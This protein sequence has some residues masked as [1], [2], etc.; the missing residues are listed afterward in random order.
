MVETFVADLSHLDD[1]QGLVAEFRD[2]LQRGRPYDPALRQNLQR[3]FAK[4][5]AE[6]LLAVDDTG[7]AVGYVQQRYRYSLWYGDMEATLEDLFVSAATRRQ[8]VATHLLRF[9]IERAKDR[10]CQTIKLDTN[11]SNHDAIRLYQRTGF[12]SGSTRF[13]NSRQLSFEKYLGLDS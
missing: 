6:F 8:G 4:G 7:R 10:G 9:A 12:L 1:L 2:L 3:L 11:E 13:A 5:E